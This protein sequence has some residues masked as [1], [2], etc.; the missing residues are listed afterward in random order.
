MPIEVSTAGNYTFIQNQDN[1][2][3]LGI[4][5]R[6]LL[7]T[8]IVLFVVGIATLVGQPIPGFILGLFIMGYMAY[9]GFI[10]LWLILPSMFIGVIFM[11]WKSGG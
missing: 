5:E 11:G 1:T 7:A 10:E 2:Y 6:I 9:I 3:G 4:F 8:I